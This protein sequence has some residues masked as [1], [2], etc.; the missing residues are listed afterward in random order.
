MKE[1]LDQMK[2]YFRIFIIL[3]I[4][5]V[6]LVIFWVFGR[7]YCFKNFSNEKDITNDIELVAVSGVVPRDLLA[8][9]IIQKF[10]KEISSKEEPDTIVLLAS[11]YFSGNL[12][13]DKTSFVAPDFSVKSFRGLEVD[14]SLL[15]KLTKKNGFCLKS[16]FVEADYAVKNLLPC[17]KNNF[18]DVKILPILIPPN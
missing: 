4:L 1:G 3:V 10:F 14:N 2:L 11:A 18:S 6:A 16:S 8:E 7:V 12:L 17:I 5:L 15:E 13:C 9:P